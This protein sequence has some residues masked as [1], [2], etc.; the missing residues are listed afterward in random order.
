MAD[1]QDLKFRIRLF[2]G[3]A[4]NFSPHNIF[5]VF[6]AETHHLPVFSARNLQ[7]LKVAQKVAHII[8]VGHGLSREFF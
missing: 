8:L 4:F 7:T 1:A 5:P 6:Q 2:L 3:I